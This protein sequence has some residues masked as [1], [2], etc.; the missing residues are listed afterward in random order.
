MAIS[1]SVK[2]HAQGR[3]ANPVAAYYPVARQDWGVL[4]PGTIGTAFT[5][6]GN[7]TNV[8]SGGSLAT[9]TGAFQ[10]TFVTAQGETTPSAEA[11]VSVT[12]G[13]S[14]SVTVSITNQTLNTATQSTAAPI[15]GWNVYSGNGSGNELLNATAAGL[16]N[17][18]LST[19]TTPAGNVITYIPIAVTS[20][21][22]T[23]YGA[24]R[25]LPAINN[26][27]VQLPLPSI[28][29]A[30]TSDLFIKVPVPFNI[31]RPTT[32]ERPN[33]VADPAGVALEQCDVVAPLWPVNTAIS[34]AQVKAGYFIVI[35]NQCFQAIV[36]GTTGTTA[37]AV[38][39]FA[40]V[41]KWGTIVDNGVT[42]LNVGRWHLLVMRWSNSTAGALQP[43]AN[44]YNFY[45]M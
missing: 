31:A 45:Q 24:G 17:Q 7:L 12:G 36:A 44:E 26:S 37:G 35:G 39:N 16:N 25:A 21:T 11:T 28:G 4:P 20:V 14:G 32:Y 15:I 18:A 38:P 2:D 10:I 3:S 5:A 33:A 43:Q 42:W 40:S 41:A 29:A 9:S 27:G 22:V 23:V 6:G 8:G 13:P 34:A 1:L 19:M 30:T